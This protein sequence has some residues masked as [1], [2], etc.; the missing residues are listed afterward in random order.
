VS[1]PIPEASRRRLAL[2]KQI[3]RGLESQGWERVT[4]RELGRWLGA[5]PDTVRKDLAGTGPGS[6]GAAYEIVDLRRRLEALIP[7][8][9]PRKTVLAGLG[10]LG[11]ALALSPGPWT[12][13][14][15]FDGRPNR[16][17][18]VEVPFPIYSTTEIVPV[19]LRMGAEAAVLAVGAAEAQKV[20]ERLVQAG[21]KLLV[22]YSPVVLRVD[23]NKI[24]VWEFGGTA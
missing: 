18:T 17:E 16:L 7:D 13:A 9:G 14:A 15:G 22:N 24:D 11:V 4:S 20:A 10:D 2:L 19:C 5:T 21:V 3:L 12:F 8:P 6:P 23:R 1:R